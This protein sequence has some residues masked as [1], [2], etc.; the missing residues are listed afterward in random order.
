MKRIGRGVQRRLTAAV[1]RLRVEGR[2]ALELVGLPGLAAVLPWRWCFA[3]FRLLARWPLLYRPACERA[4]RSAQ[5]MGLVE[6]AQRWRREYRL[7]VLVD[8]ADHYL[9]RTR[10]TAWLDK[11][12]R[13]SGQWGVAGQGGLVVSF[14]WGCGLWGLRHARVHGLW[15]HALGG[16]PDS[17]RG[18]WV[19]RRYIRARLRTL[20]LVLNRPV[21]R[22]PGPMRAVLRAWA[23][24]EQVT[25]TIDVPADQA[26]ETLPVRVLERTVLAPAA[27]IQLAVRRRIP[28]TVS[29]MG[30]DVR[31]GQRHLRLVPLGVS[32]N[33]EALLEKI[34]EYFDGLLHEQPAAWHLWS[35][36]E[37]FFAA[38]PTTEDKD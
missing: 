36:A 37:R 4:L 21:I 34:F 7:V 13:V 29:V 20:E 15:P 3:L 10:T 18:R 23:A 24:R 26:G 25:V 8:H 22:V 9:A 11:H 14:H 35:E 32:D 38:L 6:D 28:V 2:D 16:S 5:A 1:A 33:A 12:A 19:L 31:T 30:L 17:I 27:L